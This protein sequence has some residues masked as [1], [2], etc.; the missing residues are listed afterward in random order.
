MALRDQ[1]LL[2]L[3]HRS[4]SAPWIFDVLKL[5]RKILTLQPIDN[6]AG[7]NEQT[8]FRPIVVMAPDSDSDHDLP[9]GKTCQTFLK[10]IDDFRSQQF[11]LA[12]RGLSR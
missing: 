6:F 11:Q 10:Q 3:R 7:T 4:S 8:H 12:E 9:A 2:I 5:L 1:Q